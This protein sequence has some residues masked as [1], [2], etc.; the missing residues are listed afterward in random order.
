MTRIEEQST[1]SNEKKSRR[2]TKRAND[3]FTNEYLYFY[4]Y[5]GLNSR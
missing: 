5:E 4:I 1:N 2:K 3:A